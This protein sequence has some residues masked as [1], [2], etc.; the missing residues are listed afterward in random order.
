MKVN[1]LNNKIIYIIANNPHIE[2]INIINNITLTADSVIIRLNGDP[3]NLMNKIFVGKC[4]LMFYRS[5]SRSYNNFYIK[6]L[7][8]Y[9]KFIFTQWQKENYEINNLSNKTKN[10]LNNIPL[11]TYTLGFLSSKHKGGIFHGASPTTG[12][13]VL[14]NILE[15][16]NYKK[17][18]LIGFPNL[19]KKITNKNTMYGCHNI[20]LENQYF[21]NNILNN[22]SN[23]EWIN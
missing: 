1:E 10:M 14:E 13:G 16:I 5:N 4:D 11:N 21:Q 18:I 7:D 2:N 19:T 20:Y 22:Y 15:G 17:I 12:F 6:D 9:K 23:I 8:K 3:K